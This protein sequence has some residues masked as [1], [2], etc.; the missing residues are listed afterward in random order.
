MKTKEKE[1][2]KINYNTLEKCISE[3]WDKRNYDIKLKD[4]E[5]CINIF[6]AFN[7][8]YIDITKNGKSVRGKF[9]IL[10]LHI[11]DILYE[12]KRS[13]IFREEFRNITIDDILE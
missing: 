1:E 5:D 11:E 3:L 4:N 2:V 13:G 10:Q 12:V 6:E 7:Y 8:V 9:H